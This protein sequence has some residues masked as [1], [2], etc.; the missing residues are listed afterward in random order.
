MKVK[1]KSIL[2]LVVLGAVLFKTVACSS[3]SKRALNGDIS[4]AAQ[5]LLITN[6]NV[7][8]AQGNEI[9]SNHHVLVK[10]GRIAVIDSQLP[11]SE[12][13]II[14]NGTDKFVIPG[15]IDS[16]V[17]LQ[18]S[19]ND[20]GVYLAHGVTFIREMS[21]NKE[22]LA[23]SKSIDNGEAGPS[24]EVSSEKIASKSGLWGFINE[25]FWNRINVSTTQDAQQL[26]ETLKKDGFANAKIAGDISREMYLA[27]TREAKQQD[28]SVVGHIPYQITFDDFMASHHKEIAHIEELVK[29]IN[30]E[31][32]YYNDDT[33]ER[34][35][36]FVRQR[37]KQMAKQLKDKKKAV[38]TTLWYMQS[39]PIQIAD[40]AA[41]IEQV[42]LSFTN[43][44]RVDEWRPGKNNFQENHAHNYRW[45]Q[46][47]AKA[48][49]VMFEALVEEG[50]TILAGT[51]AMTTMVVPG[52]SLH[53]ELASLVNAGMTPQQALHSATSEPA[54]WMN[55][56]VGSVKQGYRADL[57]ILTQ[58]PLDDITATT[59]I[60]GV[61]KGGR[62][63]SKSTLDNMLERVRNAYA[64]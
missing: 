37:G 33:A 56:K 25:L 17:H 38:G 14:I 4:E 46:V 26:I 64:N 36:L 28:M 30:T 22:H 10:N 42:D 51:D 23:W 54:R 2:A 27:V 3:V 49:E 52:Y 32:G 41:L 8:N 20:L 35:L 48:N 29:L 19:S 45:W 6:A 13:A 1:M 63:F 16:H 60:D 62:Y 61:I 15:L 18:K 40:L 12:G 53:Q 58:N 43:P 44:Q 34:F 50:V 31:F 5:D 47:F 55:R 39:V 59:A 9:L 21:G 7:L 11:E 24:I 57:L